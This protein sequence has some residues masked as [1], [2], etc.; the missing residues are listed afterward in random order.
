M[1]LVKIVFVSPVIV[2]ALF[3]TAYP[4]GHVNVMALPFFNHDILLA[5]AVPDGSKAV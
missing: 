5:V 1:P 3:G 2:G 4:E